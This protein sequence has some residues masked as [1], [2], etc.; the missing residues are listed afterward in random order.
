MIRWRQRFR[1]RSVEQK[2]LYLLQ[3]G[4]NDAGGCAIRYGSPSAGASAAGRVNGECVRDESAAEE[5]GILCERGPECCY[6]EGCAAKGCG[7]PEQP[8]AGVLDEV[9][10]AAVRAGAVRG[11]GKDE[12]GIHGEG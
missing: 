2:L 8:R 1:T 11:D 7:R 6:G 10:S 9:R 4:G 5:G 12:Y 3:P